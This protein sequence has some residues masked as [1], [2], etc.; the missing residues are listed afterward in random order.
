MSVHD[1]ALLA[2]RFAIGLDENATEDDV[3]AEYRA[4]PHAIAIMAIEVALG[5]L[6]TEENAS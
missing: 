6:D 3:L 5:L 2:L 4:V 1:E